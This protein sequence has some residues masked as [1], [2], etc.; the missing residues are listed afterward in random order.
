MVKWLGQPRNVA[1]IPTHLARKIKICL[2]TN[3]GLVKY[4][5]QMR[6]STNNDW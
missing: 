1:K 5:D 2:V 4:G 6:G 3:I